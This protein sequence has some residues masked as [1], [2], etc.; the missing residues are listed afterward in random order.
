MNDKRIIPL[1]LAVIIALFS[2]SRLFADQV[3]VKFDQGWQLVALPYLPEVEIKVCE[4]FGADNVFGVNGTQYIDCGALEQWTAGKGIW[5]YFSKETE[6]TIPGMPVSESSPFSIIL[7]QGW[8][9]VGNPFLFDI[10]VDGGITIDDKAFNESEA[11][12][13][14]VYSYD[15]GSNSYVAEDTLE[16]WSGYLIYANQEATLKASPTRA[17]EKTGPIAEIRILSKSLQKIGDIDISS[18]ENVALKAAGYDTNG[19]FVKYVSAQWSVSGDAFID[20]AS[21]AEEITLTGG[22]AGDTGYVKAVY[23]EMS[24]STGKVTTLG[25]GDLYEYPYSADTEII[26]DD[27]TGLS[28]VA[29]QLLIKFNSEVSKENAL[30]IIKA[31]GAHVV[32]YNGAAGVYQIKT[33]ASNISDI[34]AEFKNNSDVFMAVPNVLMKVNSYPNDPAFTQASDDQRW[35]YDNVNLDDVWGTLSPSSSPVIAVIDSGV[36]A[37][38]PELSGHIVTGHNFIDPGAPDDV[39]DD[40]GHGTAVA[41]VIAAEPDNGI[42]LAG[43]CP[44]CMIMPLKVCDSSGACPIF[45]VGNA[46]TYAAD[47]GADV[48]NLS[49]GAYMASD[50]QTASLLEV[51]INDAYSKGALLVAAAGNDNM[52]SSD[53]Y[54]SGFYRTFSVAAINKN[55][56]RATFSNYGATVR[57]A[58]PGESIYTTIPVSQGSYG[59]R[60][61]TSI[62][63]G[64]VSGLAGLLLSVLPSLNPSDV[65]GLIQATARPAK[66]DQMIGGIVDAEGLFNYLSLYNSAPVISEVTQDKYSVEISGA[67]NL[68]VVAS[69]PEGAEIAIKWKVSGGSITASGNDAVWVLPSMRGSYSATVEAVD[70][71]GAKSSKSVYVAVLNGNLVQIKVSPFEKTLKMGDTEKYNAECY[72]DEAMHA[73]AQPISCSVKWEVIGGVGTIDADGNLA[74]TAAGEGWVRAYVGSAFGYTKVFVNTAAGGYLHT[75][76]TGNTPCED[77][78]YN[79]RCNDYNTNES[80]YVLYPKLTT[81]WAV[82]LG[83]AMNGQAIAKDGKIYIGTQNNTIVCLNQT[84]GSTCW[85][86]Q[87]LAPASGAV[88]ENSAAF[89]TDGNYIY[90]VS[91]NGYLYKINI[92]NGNTEWSW[93][94]FNEFP[95]N[96]T[97]I[98]YYSSVAVK[99]DTSGGDLIFI[100]SDG[101]NGSNDRGRIFAIKDNTTYASMVWSY[102]EKSVSALSGSFYKSAALISN[103]GGTDYVFAANQFKVYMVDLATG[104]MIRN[105]NCS[106]ACYY[107]PS[108]QDYGGTKYLYYVTENSFNKFDPS[109]GAAIWSPQVTFAGGLSTPAA[110]QNHVFYLG[111]NNGTGNIYAIEDQGASYNLKWTSTPILSKGSMR[112][113][114]PTV[115]QRDPVNGGGLLYTFLNQGGFG[116]VDT[117]SGSVVWEYPTMNNVSVSPIILKY[118]SDYEV[119]FGDHSGS[120]YAFERNFPPVVDSFQLEPQTGPTIEPDGVEQASGTAF[121]SDPNG[122]TDLDYVVID[123]TPINGSSAVRFAHDVGNL[124]KF[125]TQPPNSKIVVPYGVNAGTYTLTLTAYDKGGLTGSKT[126]TIV[127]ANVAPTIVSATFSPAYIYRDNTDSSTLTVVVQDRNNSLGAT[128]YVKVDVDGLQGNTGTPNWKTLTCGAFDSSNRS[129]CT[130]TVTAVSSTSLGNHTL[131]VQVY[132][133]ST[134]VNG[135]T[136]TI[137]IVEVDHYVL[138]ASPSS[139]QTGASSTVQIQAYSTYGVISTYNNTAAISITTQNTSGTGIA[140]S[141]TNVTDN[142][143]GNATLG[144]GSFSSGVATIK[145]SNTKVEANVKVK[146]TDANSKT[147]TSGNITWTVGNPDHLAVVWTNSVPPIAINTDANIQIT[148]Y[149][150]YDNVCTNFLNSN[151]FNITYDPSTPPGDPSDLTYSGTGISSTG[152]GTASIN[153]GSGIFTNGVGLF[154][155]RDASDDANIKF[156]VTEKTTG[157]TGTSTGVT[158]NLGALDHFVL[159]K[160]SP[161]GNPSAGDDAEI[162]ISAY[163]IDGNL[164]S[165]YNNTADIVLTN[166]GTAATIQWSGTGVSH[167][168][169]GNGALAGGNFSG[170][171]ATVKVR[172]TTAETINLTI[173]EQDTGATLSGTLNN[174]TWDPGPLQHFNVTAASTSAIVGNSVNVSI[175]AK[176]QY[177][178][179]ITGYSNPNGITIS[180][181]GGTLS[182]F[183]WSGAG[184]TDNGSPTYTAT[185][186]GSVFT[187]GIYEYVAVTDTKID[188]GVKVVVAEN[189]TLYSGQSQNINWT[190]GALGSLTISASPVGPIAAGQSTVATITAY[191]IYGNLKTDFNSNVSLSCLNGTLSKLVWSGSGVTPGGSG[192]GTLSG[193]SFVSGVA[194]ANLTDTVP[195]GP[196]LLQAKQGTVTGQ[197]NAGNSPTWT[198]GPLAG[199]KILD[200][201]GCGGGGIEIGNHSMN[202]GDILTSYA[203]GYDAYNNCIGDQSVTW[204]VTGTLDPIAAGPSTSSLFQPLNEAT[205]GTIKAD[206]GSGMTDY[207]GTIG[208]SSSRPTAPVLAAAGQV[209][210]IHL[211]WNAV[212][213]YEDGRPL[214]PASLQYKIY[215]TQDPS[216]F[217]TTPTYTTSLGDTT[218]DD[219]AVTNFVTYYY[220]IKAWIPAPVDIESDYS[221][222]VSSASFKTQYTGGKVCGAND[223]PDVYYPP[224]TPGF[225]NRPGDL[226]IG[227]TVS[228]KT[229][230]YIYV[231][232]TDNNRISVFDEDCTFYTTW[233]SYGLNLENY[234]APSGILYNSGKIYV[235]DYVNRVLEATTSDGVTQRAFTASQVWKLGWGAGGNILASSLTDKVYTIDPSSGNVLSSFSA[236]GAHGVVYNPTNGYIYVS[237]SSSHI[238]RAYDS[239][240]TE[241]ASAKL[242]LGYGSAYYYM[243]NPTDLT[244]DAAGNVYVADTGNSRI[245]IFDT[246]GTL[247]NVVSTADLPLGKIRSPMGISISPRTNNLWV[248]DFYNNRVVEF[249]IPVGGP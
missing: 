234:K 40:N 25:S 94:P 105:F 208:V 39:T 215:R 241:V 169:P 115:Y 45:S 166:T 100:L 136:G 205:S 246:S 187:N 223:D 140:Y 128:G 79:Q 58:A 117:V 130:T 227:D 220:K 160:I 139:L 135:T 13:H 201:A 249:V 134:T 70:T 96:F 87:S 235:A 119:Y 146:V 144:I 218:Y 122:L 66:S 123:L 191:D 238:V 121:V 206:A 76:S 186:S 147:G 47:N 82:S 51:I 65:T 230:N 6:I 143:S 199:V 245:L 243:N 32:G 145:I 196:I 16:P 41:G 68:H 179:T 61:G 73:G 170:G 138:T 161:P 18:G 24:A 114:P 172:N 57:T 204:S 131:P 142:G 240:G 151:G 64:Y 53:F 159:A 153:S 163:D 44:S 8:N 174:V 23:G 86:P 209:S 149:D 103:I 38:H 10:P 55:D 78:W 198:T 126:A 28:E 192:T 247:L 98:K 80:N 188:S 112:Y 91:S 62:S 152:P 228:G 239:S 210:Q 15:S 84:D 236:H 88:I 225:L 233:G 9:I 99:A 167:T 156:K 133:S 108:I 155:V 193:A 42:G 104:S 69:D 89:S 175:T 197:S 195:E 189:V 181:T 85:A 2:F 74:A 213:T 95:A 4:R 132:D 63:A 124:A 148:V 26:T 120:F 212:T 183:T 20:I 127:V 93:A 202:V 14:L 164:L 27:A 101:E 77:T 37:T 81:R 214:D 110:Y 35:G 113:I 33:D 237:D 30:N 232:D 184:I 162:T 125:A 141:G 244:V 49:I 48:I 1:I 203:V 118:N 75:A 219:T 102:P 60:S 109:T 19:R 217:P 111:T 158:W 200:A 224:S 180:Q 31:A 173:Y 129:T 107:T 226:V 211:S 11:V 171:M 207:T 71:T 154:K 165:N 116:T 185:L 229:V 97:S 242:G 54:P 248:S 56:G 176:D 190:P 72:D 17:A 3:T 67:V 43:V 36:D 50:S 222:Q 46:I 90:V 83:S 157:V 59:Y 21:Q 22:K 221:N 29:G 150:L 5:V 194:T 106:A 177:E 182:G 34:E 137:V 178:N 52:D 12:K 231:A 216:S 7:K 92:T 168:P